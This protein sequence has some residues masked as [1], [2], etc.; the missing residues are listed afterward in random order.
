M[1][2]RGDQGIRGVKAWGIVNPASCW[3]LRSHAGMT[4][5][6]TLAAGCAIYCFC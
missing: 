5:L 2:T 1:Q 6:A 4:N 3:L